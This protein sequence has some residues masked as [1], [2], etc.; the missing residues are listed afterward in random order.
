M[1]TMVAVLSVL[2]VLV[3]VAPLSAAPAEDPD[4]LLKGL[5][6][7]DAEDPISAAGPC[8]VKEYCDAGGYV[9]CWGNDPSSTCTAGPEYVE[10]DG[11]RTECPCQASLN[12]YGGPISCTGGGPI[13]E[14]EVG[15]NF[16]NCNEHYTYCPVTCTAQCDGG[17]PS[18][19]GY[20]GPTCFEKTISQGTVYIECD[21]ERTYCDEVLE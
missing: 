15:E 9:E 10:C 14:C 20:N 21:G 6:W 7:L 4:T 18:C 5:W 3:T 16:V 17:F 2:L 12:C 19:N 1:K 13:N 11:E 8:Y